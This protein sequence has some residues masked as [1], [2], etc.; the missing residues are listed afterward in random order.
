MSP[1]GRMSNGGDVATGAARAL[2]HTDGPAS[3]VPW[4]DERR[5]AFLIR[6]AARL[7]SRSLALFFPRCA[8]LLRRACPPFASTAD[9]VFRGPLVAAGSVKRRSIAALDYPCRMSARLGGSPCNARCL[10]HISTRFECAERAQPHRSVRTPTQRTRRADLSSVTSLYRRSVDWRIAG[11]RIARS[12][13]KVPA[14]GRS[15]N[16]TNA[17]HTSRPIVRAAATRGLTCS[18]TRPRPA[19]APVPDEVRVVRAR[20]TASHDRSVPSDAYA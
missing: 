4:A 8:A 17:L 18:R 13:K 15:T 10:A 19:R 9:C 16:Q 2:A 20:P 1:H 3:R 5:R 6:D 14:G 12:I 11:R 7:L